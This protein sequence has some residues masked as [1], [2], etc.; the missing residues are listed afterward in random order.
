VLYGLPEDYFDAYRDRVRAVTA[1]DVQRAAA[2]HLHADA[3]Q[4]VVVGDPAAVRGSLEALA[5]GEL[6]VWDADGRPM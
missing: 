4:L 6:R 3:L 2:R 5:F 1:A